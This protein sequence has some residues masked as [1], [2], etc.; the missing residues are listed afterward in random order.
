MPSNRQTSKR[1]SKRKEGLAE[2]M[3]IK[4][5]SLDPTSISVTA[6]LLLNKKLILFE[7]SFL[8]LPGFS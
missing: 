7:T 3:D 8:L 5:N 6:E 2:I 4:E 1:L